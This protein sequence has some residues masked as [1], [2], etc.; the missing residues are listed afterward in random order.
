MYRLIALFIVM[1]LFGSAVLASEENPENVTVRVSWW[2]WNTPIHLFAEY[3][4]STDN[5]IESAYQRFR[6]GSGPK[7]FEIPL[8][9]TSEGK[10]RRFVDVD[11]MIEYQKDH[12]GR[13]STVVAVRRKGMNAMDKEYRKVSGNVMVG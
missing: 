9:D 6:T 8:P 1:V 2:R 7:E 10:T 4:K 5:A 12:G 3:P 11:E 13:I